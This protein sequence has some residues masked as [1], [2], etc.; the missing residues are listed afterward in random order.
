M[1]NDVEATGKT[2]EVDKVTPIE[3]IITLV[4]ELLIS[5]GASFKK[6]GGEFIKDSEMK[7]FI[8]T[9]YAL[10]NVGPYDTTMTVN[11]GI[12]P[13]STY[14]VDSR[15]A[16]AFLMPRA[17]R[18]PGSG[19]FRLDVSAHED[20]GS[21]IMTP[22][23]MIEFQYK[24]M[25]YF[26]L[27]PT[28]VDPTQELSSKTLSDM[29]EVSNGDRC[30]VEDLASVKSIPITISIADKLWDDNYFNYDLASVAKQVVVN[31]YSNLKN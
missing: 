28:F 14:Q 8:K 5:V 10:S 12:Y 20:Q 6:V 9:L 1:K 31:F 2:V 4:T 22:A 24:F 7:K 21:K 15:I 16:A 3:R 29:I 13:I 19:P 23:E 11:G 25:N 27:I 18:M 30:H 26:K 17:V